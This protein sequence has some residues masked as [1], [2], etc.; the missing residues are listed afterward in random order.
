MKHYASILW[1]QNIKCI[2]RSCICFLCCLNLYLLHLSFLGCCWLIYQKTNNSHYFSWQ[3]ISVETNWSVNNDGYWI[4][5]F[6][7]L[8]A[9]K[10]ILCIVFVVFCL[11]ALTAAGDGSYHWKECFLHLMLSYTVRLSW[12]Q[13]VVRRKYNHLYPLY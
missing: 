7:W 10:M 13:T 3:T 5:N 11:Q 12:Q 1:T 6:N 9:I 4:L 8:I 2:I